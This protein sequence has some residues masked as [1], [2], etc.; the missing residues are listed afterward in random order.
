MAKN[1]RKAFLIAV[2]ALLVVMLG[3]FSAKCFT[4]TSD[5]DQAPETGKFAPFDDPR[6]LSSISPE[7]GRSSRANKQA[8][9]LRSMFS[10]RR[11][12][13]A[14]IRLSPEALNCLS[15]YTADDPAGDASS[16]GPRFVGLIG[17]HEVIEALGSVS[18]LTSEVVDGTDEGFEINAGSVEIKGTATQMEKFVRLQL[19]IA[20][21]DNSIEFL[22]RIPDGSVLLLD[23][24]GDEP[25]GVLIVVGPAGSVGN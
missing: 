16:A 4:Q 18:G 15:G 20:Q 7:Y 1:R 5:E 10:L 9:K 25:D 24:A 13:I 3:L 12:E 22:T 6:P 17:R 23:T 21:S 2:S 19:N 11:G 14:T 8:A